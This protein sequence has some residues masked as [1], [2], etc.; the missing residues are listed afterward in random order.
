MKTA[1]FLFAIAIA[2]FYVG[3]AWAMWSAWKAVP[4]WAFLLGL[5]AYLPTAT[6]LLFVDGMGVQRAGKELKLP[7][8]SEYLARLLWP[9]AALH[10]C[11]HNA[12]PMTLLFLDLPREAAT[13][14]RMNRYV[15]GPDGWR[16]RLALWIRAQL[17]NVFD[18]RG[19]HT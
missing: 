5:T 14:K 8:L 13:T 12:L 16:K 7:E 18:W 6:W 19:V 11:A 10:N 1:K 17:L 4:A 2:V 9:L 15:D 3:W